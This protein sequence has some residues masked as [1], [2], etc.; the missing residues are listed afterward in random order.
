MKKAE[1]GRM[2]EKIAE[3]YLKKNGYQIIEKNFK[4]KYIEIDIVAKKDNIFVFIE[5]RSKSNDN[6]GNPEETV[7][8]IKK[9]KLK[10]SAFSYVIFKKYHGLYKIELISIILDK[11]KKDE[12][13]KLKHYKDII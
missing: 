2:G 4:T 9:Q 12:A 1:L 11:D 8:E 13:M 7:N 6:F 10:N 5:V 3:N